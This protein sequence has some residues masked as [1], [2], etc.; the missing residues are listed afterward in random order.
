MPFPFIA[1]ATLLGGIGSAV[2]SN[3]GAK[4]AQRDAD[5]RNQQNWMQ[6]NAYNHPMAQMQRLK[7]SGLNPNLIY[8]SSPGSATGNAGSQQAPSKAAPYQMSNPGMDFM[9]G[10]VKQAQTANLDQD[11][12]LKAAQAIKVGEDSKLTEQQRK[13]LET[14]FN[15][16]ATQ[17]QQKAL[18]AVLQTEK[19]TSE[20]KMSATTAA[21]AIVN[22][23]IAEAKKAVA[24]LDAKL[25]KNG[26]RP[27]DS[28]YL[29]L[30]SAIFGVNFSTLESVNN[31]IDKLNGSL[32]F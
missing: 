28:V 2:V 3:Q 14:N 15:N 19:L 10:A 13:L 1:L 9:D 21:T 8:G 12:I 17:E 26:I 20:T 30:F 22:N 5:R 16:I 23:D 6:Q 32:Q 29:R 7:S 24:Q 4:K 18:Q 27:T 11:A 25:A 31:A